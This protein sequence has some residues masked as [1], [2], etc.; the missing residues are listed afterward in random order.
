MDADKVRKRIANIA[1]SPKNVRFDELA[2]LLD[3]HICDL[4]PRKYN[5]RNPSGSHHAFTVGNQ[6]F[7]VRK[8]S[9]GCVNQVYV[10][11]FLNAMEELG[12]YER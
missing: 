11:Q 6:T 3:N 12:L 2:T 7:T 5:H 8:P 1:S 4:F 9:S 10:N